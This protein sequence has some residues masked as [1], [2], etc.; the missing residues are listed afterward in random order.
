M[1]ILRHASLDK[2][3]MYKQ[4]TIHLFILNIEEDTLAQQIKVKI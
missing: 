3:V 4:K 2:Y 1:K